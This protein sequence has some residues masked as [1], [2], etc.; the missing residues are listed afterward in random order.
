ML[1]GASGRV[2]VRVVVVL[3]LVSGE[4]RATLPLPWRSAEGTAEEEDETEMISMLLS[5]SKSES[6]SITVSCAKVC[7]GFCR[8]LPLTAGAPALV[9]ACPERAGACFEGAALDFSGG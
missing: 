8:G 3:E 1:G 5:G 6:R 2:V 9:P 7:F 4:G